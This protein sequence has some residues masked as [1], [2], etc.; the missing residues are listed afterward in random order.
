MSKVLAVLGA[1]GQQGGA[2]VDFVLKDAEL[3]RQYKVRAITRDVDSDKSKK[4]ASMG[5]EV[6]QGDVTNKRSLAQALHGVHSLY[7]MT[8]PSFTPDGV[9]VEFHCGKLIA[10]AAVEQKVQ[11]LIFSS[12]PYVSKISHGKWK[13]AVHWDAKGK[14]EEYISTL[15]MQS[16]IVQL[17][18]FMENFGNLPFMVPQKAEDGTYH[19]SY[20]ISAKTRLPLIDV[21]SDVGK[22]V[23]T[24]L[25]SPDEFAGKTVYAAVDTYSL[26]EIAAAISRSTGKKVVYKQIP[27]EEFKAGKGFT[28][29]VLESVLSFI[30]DFEY[31]G[32]GTGSH[33]ASSAAHARGELTTFEQWLK[34]HPLKLDD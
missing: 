9:E 11:Y 31:Y 18:T 6:V 17:G 27:V 19:L 14:I 20:N 30:G 5:V 1:T 12:L 34:A 28:G 26:D 25:A 21:A 4:L 15:P 23:G 29:E 33:V 8:A 2:V 32:P 3:A 22:F 24:I 10:D 13:N 16:S 7:A